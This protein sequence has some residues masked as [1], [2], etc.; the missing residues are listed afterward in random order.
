MVIMIDCT[1]CRRFSSLTGSLTAEK[2]FATRTV[3]FAYF[4]EQLWMTHN[5]LVNLTVYR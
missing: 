2:R 3:H 5:I 1:V 4:L